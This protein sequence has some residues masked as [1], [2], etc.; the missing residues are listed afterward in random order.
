[1]QPNAGP[2][3]FI[4]LGDIGSHM[5][6]NILK[7]GFELQVFD[8]RRDAVEKAVSLGA[9]AAASVKSMA[10]GCRYISICVVNDEQV[11]HL[12]SGP[13]GIFDNAKPGTAIL[14]HSTM[15]PAAAAAFA[16]RA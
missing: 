4:G 5:A 2:V 6:A 8:L 3:G 10:A 9:R 14:S 11:E 15:P 1:M 13:D 16:A 7:G 12:V